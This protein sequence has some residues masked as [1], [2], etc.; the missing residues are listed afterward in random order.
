MVFIL[1]EPTPNP[2][3]M[4]FLPHVRLTEGRSWS[5]DRAGFDPQL[6]PLAARLFEVEGVRRVYVAAD[7]LT[8]TRETEG[9]RWRQLRYQVIQTIAEHLE[10]GDPAIT[11]TTAAEDED[12]GIEGEIKQ[13]LGR[14]VR[15]GVARDGGEVLFDRFDRQTGVLWIKMQGACGGCPSARLTLK[16]SVERIVRRYM[17]EVLSVEET[18]AEASGPNAAANLGHWMKRI[19]PG[20]GKVRTVFTHG[21]RQ[22]LAKSGA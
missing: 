20:M 3:A 9:P 19:G 12:E 13:V 8:I 5:F 6:S 17:P 16:A 2:E 14:Y 15:P 4:K 1:T 10:T 7:F 11:D 21:G 18:P 22:I